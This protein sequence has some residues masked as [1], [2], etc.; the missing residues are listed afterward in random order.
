MMRPI[1]DLPKLYIIYNIQMHT[2]G[3]REIIKITK[4]QQQQQ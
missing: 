3:L 1:D 4:Q 2:L